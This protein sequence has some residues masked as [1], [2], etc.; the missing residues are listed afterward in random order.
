MA[1]QK[2]FVNG[3]AGKRPALTGQ[4]GLLPGEPQ[5]PAGQLHGNHTNSVGAAGDVS[6]PY[7]FPK[8][9]PYR[10]WVQTKSEGRILTGVFDTTVAA[11]K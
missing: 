3:M 2:F 1:A 8:S 6:F 4:S 11:A 5:S 7:A 9:G 10:I